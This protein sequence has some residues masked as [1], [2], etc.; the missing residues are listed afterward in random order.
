VGSRFQHLPIGDS[1]EPLHSS[2]LV[3]LGDSLARI[4][5][6]NIERLAKPHFRAAITVRFGCELE[7]SIA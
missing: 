1:S 4:L 3:G 2:R 5:P 7:R 6:A